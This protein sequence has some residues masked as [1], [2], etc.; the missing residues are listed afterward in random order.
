MSNVFEF[1]AVSRVTA[2]TGSAKASRRN[3]SVPAVI[4]VAIMSQS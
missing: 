2:R 1:N 3:G 4:M